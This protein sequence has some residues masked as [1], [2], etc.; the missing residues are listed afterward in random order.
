[1]PFYIDLGAEYVISLIRVLFAN[2]I[3]SINVSIGTNLAVNSP[4][5]F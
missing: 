4:I 3:S 5:A 1:M 2:D